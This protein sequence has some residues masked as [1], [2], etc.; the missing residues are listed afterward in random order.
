MMFAVVVAV[1][2]SS[3]CMEPN[4]GKGRRTRPLNIL[5]FFFYLYR[6]KQ[7]SLSISLKVIIQD[8]TSEL[9]PL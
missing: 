3:L 1:F 5:L 2:V 7:H 4:K 6:G 9:N 8:L